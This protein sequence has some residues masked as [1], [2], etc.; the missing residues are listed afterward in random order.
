MEDTV[1]TLIDE[2]TRIMHILEDVLSPE[3]L[4]LVYARIMYDSSPLYD[5]GGQAVRSADLAPILEE[6]AVARDGAR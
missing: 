1:I 3:E 2:R 4:S 5:R 6:I